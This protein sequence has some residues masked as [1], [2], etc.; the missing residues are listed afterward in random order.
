M[1]D[2][3]RI[4]INLNQREVEVAGN[5]AFVARY[6]DRLEA[7]LGRLLDDT[8]ELPSPFAEAPA[9][10]A[11]L[12]DKLDLGPFGAFLHQLPNAATEVDKMLA[13]GFYV[14]AQSRDGSF[15]TAEANRRLVEQGIKVG[16]PSQCVRQSLS[17]KRVF[18]LS[19]GQYKVSVE[20]RRYL[21]RLMGDAVPEA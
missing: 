18:T 4:R 2:E 12:L 20:G 19:K 10:S 7:M 1:S 14:E 15:A 17:A 9:V 11:A 3:A 8:A 16:N 21:R 6:A 13:A 5:E